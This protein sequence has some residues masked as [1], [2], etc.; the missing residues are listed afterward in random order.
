MAEAEGPAEALGLA[1]SLDLTGHHVLHAVRAGL[2][3]RL[4]RPAEAATGYAK[5]AEP[6]ASE[7]ERAC[8]E[9]CRR[10]LDHRTT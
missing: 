9:R 10:G 8:L 7:A 5:A 1:D 6:A 4:D 2:L 3:R